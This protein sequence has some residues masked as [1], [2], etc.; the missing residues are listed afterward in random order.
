VKRLLIF[1]LLALPVFGAKIEKQTLTSRGETRT[2]YLFVP[3]GIDASKPVPLII[4]LHGSG[5]NGLTLVDKWM[6]LARKEKIIL[7]GPDSTNSKQWGA[8]EDG[9]VLLHDLVESLKA[10]YPID[11]RRVYLFGHSGG[12]VFALEMGLIESEYFAAVAIHAGALPEEN[13]SIMDHAT[14]KISFAIISGTDDPFF[15][16]KYVRA[17]RDELQ[18]RGFVAE[19]TEVPHHTHD[20]YTTAGATNGVAWEFLKKFSLEDDPHFIDYANMR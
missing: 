10:K 16:M 17:T 19:L 2:Y 15:P 12:A 18:K 11:E 3:D 13:A 4:T 7:A 8:P 5:R 20:Y 6:P 1:L 14:R 9:P